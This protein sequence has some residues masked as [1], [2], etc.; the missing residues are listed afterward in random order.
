MKAVS[1][2]HVGKYPGGW[3]IIVAWLALIAFAQQ[4]FITQT[5]IHF[6]AGPFSSAAL[7]Q[8][9]SAKAQKA[10]SHSTPD[11]YPSSDDPANC[12]IC[13]EIAA[14]GHFVMPAAAAL[15]L[16]AQDIY[17]ATLLLT[18]PAFRSAPSHGWQGRA[19]PRL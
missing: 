2:S 1:R 17:A 16:P 9:D 4:S 10:N 19:P 13:Q 7:A 11:K 15:T 18:A 3:R 14:T 8:T 6:A 12:P 5:H